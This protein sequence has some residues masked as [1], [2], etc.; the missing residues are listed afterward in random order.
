M[1]LAL[2]GRQ[3]NKRGIKK[4]GDIKMGKNNKERRNYSGE[5]KLEVVYWWERK[6]NR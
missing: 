5:F 6:R 4:T 2:S 3:E 1:D